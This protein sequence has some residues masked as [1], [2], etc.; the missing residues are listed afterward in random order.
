M[1]VGI[2]DTSRWLSPEEYVDDGG[3]SLPPSGCRRASLE[4]RESPQ[5]IKITLFR[6][7]PQPENAGRFD[8]CFNRTWCLCRL[9]LKVTND[10]IEEYH[11]L[12]H[13]LPGK[14]RGDFFLRTPVMAEI[15]S[16]LENNDSWIFASIGFP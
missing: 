3:P 11:S 14:A 2:R 7:R 10:L 8:S 5:E 6:R 13:W 9:N 1:W 16:L 4:R 12:F 15:A